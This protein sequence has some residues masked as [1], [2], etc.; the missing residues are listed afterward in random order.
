MAFLRNGIFHY[1]PSSP[2]PKCKFPTVQVPADDL[3]TT[4]LCALRLWF[5]VFFIN[6]RCVTLKD[7]LVPLL[8]TTHPTPRR[9]QAHA[10]LAFLCYHTVEMALVNLACS[11]CNCYGFVNAVFNW[12][13]PFWL[14]LIEFFFFFFSIS[15][16]SVLSQIQP[17]TLP[18]IQMGFEHRMSVGSCITVCRSQ[19]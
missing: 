12:V 15:R 7:E 19:S 1:P 4:S 16:F 6:S 9:M 8:G 3:A 18:S 14:F 10:L 17:H 2:S 13:A 11:V 5:S